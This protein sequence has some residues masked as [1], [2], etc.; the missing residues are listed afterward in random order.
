M[1]VLEKI[2]YIADYIE[3][4]RSFDG[5]EEMKT[6][7][8]LNLEKCMV[9]CADSTIKYIMSKGFLIH[10]HTIETRNHNLLLI[11]DLKP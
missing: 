9:L 5:I 1:S 4:V 3:P 11:K 8:Y 2:I 10:H 7:A 6:E